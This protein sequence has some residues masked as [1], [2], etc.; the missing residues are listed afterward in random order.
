MGVVTLIRTVVTKNEIEVTV[1]ANN[2]QVHMFEIKNRY[3]TSV[4]A[5]AGRS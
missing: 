1:M 3:C 2:S 4:L 5:R